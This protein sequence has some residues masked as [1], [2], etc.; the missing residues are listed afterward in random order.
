MLKDPYTSPFTKQVHPKIDL[1]PSRIWDI[2]QLCW[3]P[4]GLDIHYAED[5]VRL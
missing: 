2:F 4:I 3:E 1:D 5:V